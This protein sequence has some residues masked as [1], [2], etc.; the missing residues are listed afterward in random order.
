ML[1]IGKIDNPFKVGLGAGVNPVVAA[2]RAEA[3]T[4]GEDNR[5]SFKAVLGN[6]VHHVNETAGAPDELMRQ[7]MTTGEVDV[8]D[9]M[10]ANAKSE[11]VVSVT[12]QIATKVIQAYDRI[13]Q[14]QI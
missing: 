1:S 3:P 14:I 2:F 10:I 11:L 4:L 5:A 7:A 6:L 9:V 13:K 12:T 8:H